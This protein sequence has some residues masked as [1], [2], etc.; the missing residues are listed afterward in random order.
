M[1]MPIE[2]V[3]YKGER[4]GVE[5]PQC[6]CNILLVP[7]NLPYVGC[8]VCWIRGIIVDDNGKMKV[9]WHMEDLKL[10]RFGSEG[11]AHHMVY[12]GKIHKER[13]GANNN[14]VDVLKKEILSQRKLK[15]ISPYV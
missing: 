13:T 11:L 10:Q 4:A 2:E 6:H 8:P 9:D 15:V 1:D 12:T 3:E 14:E 5:C 7:E